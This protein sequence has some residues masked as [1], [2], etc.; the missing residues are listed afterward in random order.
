[1][2]PD[3]AVACLGPDA[4]GASPHFASWEASKE[5][6]RRAVAL[7]WS[8]AGSKVT[9]RPDK[10]VSLGGAKD[11]ALR[12]IVPPNT[13]GT[14]LDVSVTDA[15]GHRATLGRVRVDGLPGTER[16]ASYWAREVRVPLTAASRAGLDLRRIK[17]L[18]LTP[19]SRSGQ[20][21]LMDAWGWRP[22]TPAAVP[23][24]LPRV[25][26]GRL[27]V[28][29]GDSG[30][31][32]YRV[33]VQVSGHGSGQVRVYVDDPA[34][35]QDTSRLVTVRPGGNAIDVPVKVE[36]NTRFDYGVQHDVFVKAVHG[37]VVGAH[38]GGVTTENDDPMPTFTVTPV[39]DRV[40]EGRPLKWKV[41]LSA[42]ADVELSPAFL[43][44]PIASGTELSTLDVDP[45]W[46]SENSGEQPAP[47]RPL[48]KVSSLFLWTSVP[49]GQLSAEI[50]VPTITDQVTEQPESVRF[51]AVDENGDPQS[52]GPELTGT[53]LDAS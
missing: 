37:A 52:G 43:V 6:G 2:D 47:E 5:I 17:S 23:A 36:G 16:T 49:A 41:T 25:D 38:R 7:R 30:V 33:P 45:Q 39:A 24:S 27:T 46:L 32:T 18:E 20:A 44:Q 13:I 42:L 19:R 21:W 4:K 48:S 15:S 50:S 29:E 9:A 10:P 3:P 12:V 34:T 40:T 1:V 26:I 53:V 8:A 35:G 22:G 28:K 14:Q 31:K 51:Q 11:L